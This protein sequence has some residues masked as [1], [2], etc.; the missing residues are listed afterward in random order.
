MSI[1]PNLIP[2][3]QWIMPTLSV[4]DNEQRL[5]FP[6]QSAFN[7][8][9]YDAVGGVVLGFRL[10]QRAISLLTPE[11]EPLQRRELTL[12]TAFPGLG[13]RDCFELVSR[14]V[15]ENRFILD[16]DFNGTEAQQG[17]A[18]RFYFEFGYRGKTVA[19]A[20][21]AG[22]PTTEFLNI[23]RASKRPDATPEIQ[24]QWTAAKY[25]LANTLLSITPQDA[26]RVL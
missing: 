23:G 3:S 10:L 17:I 13:A 7:Y 21:V 20:P 22:Q 2:E 5:S 26:I 16:I 1:N 12:F 19:L 18:G 11:G 6:I 9:G 25:Q 8:H 4:A 15:S 14:I 24:R